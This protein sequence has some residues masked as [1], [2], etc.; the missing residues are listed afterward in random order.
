MTMIEPIVQVLGWDAKGAII[1]NAVTCTQN[2]A[3][4][5][6]G[7]FRGT[8]KDVVNN[9]TFMNDNHATHGG[10]ICENY[11]WHCVPAVKHLVHCVK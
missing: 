10:C 5:F 11:I 6:G 4:N 8:G 1:F 9:G 7:C 3:V 2:T